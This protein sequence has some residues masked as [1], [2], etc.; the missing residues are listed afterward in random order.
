MSD[1]KNIDKH[2]LDSKCVT[3]AE[4]FALEDNIVNTSNYTFPREILSANIDRRDKTVGKILKV[5]YYYTPQYKHHTVYYLY[6]NNRD[7]CEYTTFYIQPNG[8]PK[9][10]ESCSMDTS[11]MHKIMDM[12]KLPEDNN[13]SISP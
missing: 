3:P 13:I 12:Y 1:N 9:F 5:F 10:L 11:I 6:E 8:Y 4:L 2:P 7:K